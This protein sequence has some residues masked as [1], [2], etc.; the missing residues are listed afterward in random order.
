MSDNPAI[1]EPRFS[2]ETL[3]AVERSLKAHDLRLRP[4]QTLEAVAE[5][6]ATAGIQME[7]KF[8]GLAATQHGQPV[9][10]AQAFE[11]LANTQP[12]KF[13]PREVSNVRSRD[14]MDQ[15]A[16]VK[17]IREQGL[18]AFERLPQKADADTPVVFDRSRMT[19]AHYAKLPPSVKTELL[20]TWTPDD[21]ARI[22]NRK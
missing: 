4:G 9:H 3:G 20:H 7:A 16:K 2:D 12:E 13:Y 11:G 5:A 19:A 17:F 6:F 14:E 8:G 1:V 15:T 22:I 21:I 18:E 10:V